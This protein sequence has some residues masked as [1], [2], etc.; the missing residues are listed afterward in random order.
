MKKSG[1][2]STKPRVQPVNPFSSTQEKEESNQLHFHHFVKRMSSGW[3]A[4]WLDDGDKEMSSRLNG[5]VHLSQ[6]NDKA[7]K[8]GREWVSGLKLEWAMLP[9]VGVVMTIWRRRIKW[10]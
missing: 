8:R 7:V 1:M 3:M 6:F 10:G 4:N 2:H 5:K 9:F